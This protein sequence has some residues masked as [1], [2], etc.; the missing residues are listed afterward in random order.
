[1]KRHVAVLLLLSLFLTAAV[2]PTGENVTLGN[3]D[4][5]AYVSG[6]RIDIIGEMQ[7]DL[8]AAAATITIDNV[9][10]DDVT[11]AAKNI[12]INAPVGGD[13][14][15]AGKTVTASAPI[16]GDAISAAKTTRFHAPVGGDLVAFAD[17]VEVHDNVTGDLTIRAG[18]LFLNGT[19]AGNA[20]IKTDTMTFGS[21]G[22]IEGDATI[23]ENVQLNQARIGGALTLAAVTG[24]WLAIL[25]GAA[26]TYVALLAL[27]ALI[28][29]FF[30]ERVVTLVHRARSDWANN[31]GF[32]IAAFVAAPI[33]A[34]LCLLT[35]VGIPIAIMIGAAYTVFLV[36]AWL[37]TGF[38]VGNEI[39][40]FDTTSR[41]GRVFGSFAVGSFLYVAISF[42][43]FI[44]WA[45]HL[46]VLAIVLGALVRA[47]YALV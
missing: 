38:F 47:A 12:T 34:V 35:V 29:A 8:I 46:V 43:P 16:G 41:F 20:D 26:F 10:G 3:I 6:E 40:P 24:A 42:I 28:V 45:A 27:G 19:V 25:L 33:V 31:L 4:E 1:M 2:Y 14:R 32:G 22:R 23:T 39:I 36:V 17:T 7:H 30:K 15:V 44:G 18:H 11:A 21:D 9:V 5:N 13:V 37:M